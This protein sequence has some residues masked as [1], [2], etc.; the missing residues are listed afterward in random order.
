M[1][2]NLGGIISEISIVLILYSKFLS[3]FKNY[4]MKKT[5]NKYCSEIIS[6]AFYLQKLFEI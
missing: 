5:M 6:I 4:G 2:P 3:F 1:T